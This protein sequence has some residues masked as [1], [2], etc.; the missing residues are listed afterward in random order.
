MAAHAT[1][2]V[3]VLARKGGDVFFAKLRIPRPDGTTF[4]PQ[5]RLG[6][7]WTKRT[8][9]PHGYL[10]R[11]QAEARLQAILDGDDAFVSVETPRA[12]I[13]FGRCLDEWIADRD[14]ECRP[15]TMHDYRSTAESRLR[16]FF[17]DDTPITD[18]TT[19]RVNEL[20]AAMA[21]EGLSGRTINKTLALLHGVFKLVQELH[22]LPANPVATARR[23]K[24]RRRKLE[25]YLTAPEVLRLAAHA[26][27]PQDAALYELAAW[28]G[29]RWGELKALR[30]GDVDFAGGYVYVNRNHPCHGVEDVPK[31]G[32]PRAVP[33]WDQAARVLDTLSRRQNFT[34]PEDYVFVT[35]VGGPL[36]YDSATKAFR[37][38]RDAAGLT[39]PRAH[40]STLTF[41]DL[42]H[43]YGTMAAAIYGNLREVQEY[44]GHASVTTTELY[45]HFVPRLDAAARGT[46]GLTAMLA[47]EDVPPAMPRTTEMQA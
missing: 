4:E 16:P 26:E 14:H 19:D 25:Q 18:I 23:A 42:R 27:T 7:V 8:P 29:L 39:S 22:A 3:R 24:Q 1:G 36:D 40:D 43:S 46:A 37:R 11:A 41:H 20:R 9:P 38:A 15:S 21:G 35:A 30:F 12:I 47:A 31:S 32:K 44:C 34:D 13:T 6:R 45:A 5:R 33:M 2:H 28:T 10:T 17:G